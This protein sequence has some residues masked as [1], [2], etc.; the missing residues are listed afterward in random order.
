[1]NARQLA[2]ELALLE[3]TRR[4][5]L[6]AEL[7]DRKRGELQRLLGELQ[8]ILGA[9]PGTF[10]ATMANAAADAAAAPPFACDETRLNEVLRAETPAVKRQIIAIFSGAQ[11]APVTARVRAVIAAWLQ[12]QDDKVPRRRPAKFTWAWLRKA[13]R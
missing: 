6:L 8:P 9:R 10:A 1:M 7:P 12:Q 11:P 3:T 4:E 13:R 5:Q 2:A